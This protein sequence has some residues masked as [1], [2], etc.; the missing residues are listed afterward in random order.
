VA[1]C[2]LSPSS[3]MKTEVKTV[4]KIFQSIESSAGVF[5]VCLALKLL[6]PTK[7]GYR[8]EAGVQA[9]RIRR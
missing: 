9:F 7:K 3:A 6:I 5:F 8:R 2:V 4:D 1:N